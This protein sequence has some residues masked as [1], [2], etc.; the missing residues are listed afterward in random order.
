MNEIRRTWTIQPAAKMAAV[1]ADFIRNLDARFGHL[2]EFADLTNKGEEA[3]WRRL[4]LRQIAKIALLGRLS[5]AGIALPVAVRLASPADESVLFWA[6]SAAQGSTFQSA[7]EPANG[8]W[9]EKV[10]F[11]AILLPVE[12]TDPVELAL[13]RFFS[14]SASPETF[15]NWVKK[16]DPPNVLLIDLRAIGARIAREAPVRD[17]AG[18]EGGIL[19]ARFVEGGSNV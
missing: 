7:D 8:S 19:P 17:A 1:S 5:I 9:S 4:D 14:N 2:P 15:P 18:I 6:K 13:H 16:L 12:A 3:K 10:R 11:M